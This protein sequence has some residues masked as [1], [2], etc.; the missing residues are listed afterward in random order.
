MR[1]ERLWVCGPLGYL[2]FDP[3]SLLYK[4]TI[5]P[6]LPPLSETAAA[7]TSAWETLKYPRRRRP[8]RCGPPHR[9]R[10][11]SRQHRHAQTAAADTPLSGADQNRCQLQLCSPAPAC[12]SLAGTA[13]RCGRA[14][15]CLCLL[16]SSYTARD[17]SG[18][19]T[20]C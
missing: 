14:P 6:L 15:V 13:W 9:A 8:S 3:P 17:S 1:I 19:L 18:A 4:T 16:D 20:E 11:P 12:V 5:A 2:D 7:K 10:N